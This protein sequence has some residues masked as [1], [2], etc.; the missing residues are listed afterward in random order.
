M[1]AKPTA[2]SPRGQAGGHPL[3]A[4]QNPMCSNFGT[5]GSGAG[6]MKPKRANDQWNKTIERIKWLDIFYS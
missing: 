1:Q 4:A 5:L 3:R 6:V 2:A